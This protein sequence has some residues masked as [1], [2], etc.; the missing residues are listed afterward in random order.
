MNNKL[1]S[2]LIVVSVLFLAST[3]TLA[4]TYHVAQDG[5]GDFDNIVTAYNHAQ[6]GDTIIVKPGIYKEE[7]DKSGIRLD[8][9][10]TAGK[11]ITLRSEVKWG[12]VLDAGNHPGRWRVL[13]FVGSYNI[14][15]GFEIRH[16][17]AMGIILFDKA[18]NNQLLNNNIH[19]NGNVYDNQN[20]QGQCGILE[21]DKVHNTIYRGN[22]IHHNGRFSQKSHLDHGMYL[23]GSNALITNNIFTH[24]S[25]YGIQFAGYSGIES[26]KVYNNTFAWNGASGIVLWK[27]IDRVEI[28]NNIFYKNDKHAIISAGP[29]GQGT[30]I[31][32]NL[33]YG[34]N[35]SDLKLTPS[36]FF[37][38]EL[39]K[40]HLV[41]DPKFVDDENDF[42]L[43]RNSPAIGAG[44]ALGEVLTDFDGNP[45]PKGK[46]CSIGAYEYQ[47]P[48]E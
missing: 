46:P 33:W 25:A 26:S 21:Y 17:W 47:A 12:A 31:D 6:P 14:V 40:N 37:S 39:G 32:Y 16:A 43:Q 23:C 1:R 29:A 22:V 8:R 42:H 20:K 36:N 2:S 13:T 15:D 19:H 28:K 18:N 7:S 41:K 27:T 9:D 10:G 11:P 45:R 48:S 4:A 30:V 24:N 34:N 35:I 44:I 5:S 38:Y 3:K